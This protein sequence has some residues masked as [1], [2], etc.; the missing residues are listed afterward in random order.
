MDVL[1][2]LFMMSCSILFLIRNGPV[3]YR[4]FVISNQRN[5]DFVIDIPQETESDSDSD[6]DL[7]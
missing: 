6:V 3:L 7:P 2:F 4:R 5:D 1:I